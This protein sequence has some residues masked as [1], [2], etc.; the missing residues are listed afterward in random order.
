MLYEVITN[1]A[2]PKDQIGMKTFRYRKKCSFELRQIHIT[3][4]ITRQPNIQITWFFHCRIIGPHMDRE[5]KNTW[6][7]PKNAMIAIS[8]MRVRIQHENP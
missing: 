8:L 6:R 1:T 5:R 7:S 2:H 3:P 4:D